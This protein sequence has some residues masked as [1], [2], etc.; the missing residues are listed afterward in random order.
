MISFNKKKKKKDVKWHVSTE[1]YG[2]VRFHGRLHSQKEYWTKPYHFFGTFSKHKKG[3]QKTE[4][5]VQLNVIYRDTSFTY[6]T[7]QNEIHSE[8]LQRNYIYI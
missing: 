7:S 6:A 8:R 5:D 4:L 3:Y 2:L 1:W